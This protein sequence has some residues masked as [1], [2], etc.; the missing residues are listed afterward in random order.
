MKIEPYLNF[1]GRCEEA[2]KFYEQA[3]GAKAEMVLRFSDSPE[4]CSMPQTQSR[5]TRLHRAVTGAKSVSRRER[6]SRATSTCRR[7]RLRSDLR[8][9][10]QYRTAG[11]LAPADHQWFYRQ[12]LTMK[13]GS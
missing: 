2:F 7:E 9:A 6:G 5:S 10:R 3:V 1:D 8:H 4:P 12:G 13:S 11:S